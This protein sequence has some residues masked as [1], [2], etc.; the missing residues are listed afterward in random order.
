MGAAARSINL[1]VTHL[2]DND[3]P[4]SPAYILLAAAC[5][6]PVLHI[7]APAAW[8][9][10]WRAGFAFD[11]ANPGHIS[12]SQVAAAAAE[13][14]FIF[15]TKAGGSEKRSF[16]GQTQNQLKAMCLDYSL[17]VSGN[18][19]VLKTRLQEYSEKFCN[20]PASCNLEPVKRRHHKGPRDGAKKSQSKQSANRRA[21]IIDTERVTERSKDTR[22][23]D[24]VKHLLLWADR[25]LARLPYKPLA[26]QME[27]PRQ[28]HRALPETSL[29]STIFD[30]SLHDRMR[31][32]ESQLAAIAAGI[33][34]P[35]QRESGPVPPD[36]IVYDHTT[37][38]ADSYG[39]YDMD[40]SIE[41]ENWSYMPSG[42]QNLHIG[43]VFNNNACSV[44]TPAIQN[45][46]SDVSASSLCVTA[47][48][49]ALQTPSNGRTRSI[50]LGNRTVLTI[51]VAE[52]K[53]ISIPATS[54]AENIE[55]LNQMWDDTSLY[56]KDDSVVKIGTQS[57]ALIYWRDLFK[58]TGLWSAHKS[59]WTEWKFII[60]RYRQGT[61]AEFW[62]TFSSQNG[63]KMSYTAICNQLRH[64]RKD[65]DQNLADQ[66][67][68]QYGADFGDTFKYRCSKTNS[69]VIMSKASSIAKEYKQ[70]HLS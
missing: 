25:T 14:T 20:D 3:N 7:C 38:T 39:A 33:S 59:N 13:D 29:Q 24:E 51:S 8:K 45:P 48:P 66:A 21:A 31:N 42:Y 50:T 4:P 43:Q 28:N 54:F 40:V 18:K 46:I 64:E 16:T 12:S 30:H 36:F 9:R 17:P 52:I 68:R 23:A 41:S 32:M 19:T 34:G 67:R 60:K 22:T 44:T 61:P 6:L 63:G 27:S 35:D 58:N 55:R 37:D 49:A 62:T 57:I 15:P 2:L 11:M 1:L 53:K 47:A 56:W 69:W 26:P 65:A 70:L 10:L 5:L